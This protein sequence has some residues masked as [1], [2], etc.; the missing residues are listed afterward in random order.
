VAVNKIV[1]YIDYP[2]VLHSFG[3]KAMGQFFIVFRG[4]AQIHWDAVRII[5]RLSV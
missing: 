5:H 2:F 1:L 4:K 3:I